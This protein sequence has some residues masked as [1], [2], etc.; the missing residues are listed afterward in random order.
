MASFLSGQY[1][2]HGAC[3]SCRPV[4]RGKPERL[5][6]DNGANYTSTEILQACL[7]LDIKLSTPHSGWR[8]QGQDRTLFRG[9][10]IAF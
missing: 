9:L 3:L 2:E 1:C 7:R 10:E 5:Y 8:G 6:F 4:Q